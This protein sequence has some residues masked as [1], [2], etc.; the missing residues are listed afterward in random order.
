VAG[1]EGALF[2]QDPWSVEQ[3]WQELAQD[4][5]AYVVADGEE[6][7]EGYAGAFL[8]AP[9]SDVQTIGVRAD[10]R[11]RGLASRLLSALTAEARASGCTH[12]ML[13]VRADNAAAIR[14]YERHG[15]AAISRRPAYYPDGG[16]ALVMRARLEREV[17]Q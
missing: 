14:L 12:M 16:D 10:R 5:R 13:E 15:F 1:L 17:A 11:G 4:T 6:G 3:F 2:P 9:D 7:L 8:L